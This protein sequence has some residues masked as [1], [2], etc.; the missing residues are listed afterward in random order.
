VLLGPLIK[1]FRDR[2]GIDALSEDRLQALLVGEQERVGN[3]A[4]LGELLLPML[5]ERLR[6][7]PEATRPE[8]SAAT[9]ARPPGRPARR[10]SAAP[11]IADL[12]DGMLAQESDRPGA[13]A[14]HPRV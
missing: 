6:T 9:H 4:V 3:A 5:V 10:S 11:D 1:T 2:H 8:D 14:R 13:R 12:L 7:T